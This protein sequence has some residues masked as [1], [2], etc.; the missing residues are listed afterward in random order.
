[1]QNRHN[2]TTIST[3]GKRMNVYEFCRLYTE[4][5]EIMEIWSLP[6]QRTVFRGTFDEAKFSD[7][8]DREVMSFGIEDGIICIN[9]D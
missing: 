9:I 5:G 1:M 4:G 8:S 2:K 7:F 3:E 6:K